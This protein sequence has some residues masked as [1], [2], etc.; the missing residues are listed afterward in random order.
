MLSLT[1]SVFGYLWGSIL[2]AE[3]MA[4]RR[5]G[6]SLVEMGENPGAS[7]SWRI[8]GFRIGFSVMMFD[9]FKGAIPYLLAETLRLQDFWLVMP[10]VAPVVGHNWPAGRFNWGGTWS[11][12]RRWGHSECRF[13]GH[14]L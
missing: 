7:A 12:C 14:G 8:L 2:P 13:P 6:H 3:W 5:L 10:S 9:P 4:R 11:G 1:L